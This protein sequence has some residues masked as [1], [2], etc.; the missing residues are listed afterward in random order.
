M[1]EHTPQ[2]RRINEIN[3]QKTKKTQTNRAESKNTELVSGSERGR[4]RKAEQVNIKQRSFF[5]QF[6]FSFSNMSL[7]LHATNGSR[8]R[9]TDQKTKP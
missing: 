7:Y 2:P 6:Q 8:E 1:H 9:N 5:I 4:E 3:E